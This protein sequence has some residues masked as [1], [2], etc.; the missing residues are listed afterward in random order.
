MFKA[1]RKL[2]LKE[3][4]G[5]IRSTAA[6]T[7]IYDTTPIRADFLWESRFK[8]KKWLPI[9]CADSSFA[10]TSGLLHDIGKLVLLQVVGELGIKVK[11]EKEIDKIELFDTLDARKH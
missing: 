5:V 7:I 6:L 9:F 11:L 4:G 10:C 2:R 8:F 1:E 3:E